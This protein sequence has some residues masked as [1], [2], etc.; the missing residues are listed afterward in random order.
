MNATVVFSCEATGDFLNF[1]VD[2]LPTNREEI[3]ARGFDDDSFGIGGGVLRG[4]LTAKA[5]DINNNTNVTCVTIIVSTSSSVTS[6][7][8]LLLIQG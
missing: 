8:V 1:L 7:T 2:S 5:Y 6:N 3:S 4:I